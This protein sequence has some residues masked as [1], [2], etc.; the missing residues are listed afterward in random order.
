MT[1]RVIVLIYLYN[2]APLIKSQF[3]QLKKKLANNNQQVSFVFYK[4]IE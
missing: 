1:T 2:T 4:S 3:I